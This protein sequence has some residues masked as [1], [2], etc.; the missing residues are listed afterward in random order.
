MKKIKKTIK[1]SQKKNRESW[2]EIVERIFSE[3]KKQIFYFN[4][5][6]PLKNVRENY[7]ELANLLVKAQKVRNEKSLR[8]EIRKTAE[9]MVLNT[10]NFHLN[11]FQPRLLNISDE[12]SLGRLIREM[13]FTFVRKNADYG[14]AFLFWG[15]PGLV[16]RIGDKYLRLTQLS[17]KRY[18]R[19]V[20]DEKIP[21]TA[22]DLANYGIMLLMLLQGDCSLRFG[23]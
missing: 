12:K 10:V 15:I 20:Q 5:D 13:R 17:K 7:L 18:K 21:D 2:D 4:H 22:L 16:V 3:S 14:S 11:F 23:E 1:I 8:N 19:K 6:D 9:L